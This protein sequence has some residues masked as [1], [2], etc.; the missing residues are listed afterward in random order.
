[1]PVIRVG[2]YRLEIASYVDDRGSSPRATRAVYL[3]PHGSYEGTIQ[4]AYLYFIPE[5]SG[6]LTVSS[7]DRRVYAHLDVKDFKDIYHVLQTES[8]TYFDW[9]DGERFRITTDE[10][11]PGEGFKDVSE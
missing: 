7:T 8:P 5:A 11:P 1:M 4:F 2:S 10:E 3:Q 6:G 9:V